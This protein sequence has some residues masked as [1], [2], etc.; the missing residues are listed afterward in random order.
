MQKQGPS[1]ACFLGWRGDGILKKL[2]LFRWPESTGVPSGGSLWG[3][4]T[5]DH[6]DTN[7]SQMQS[8]TSSRGPSASVTGSLLERV[9]S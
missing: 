4:G 2:R 6:W 3:E 8:S 9:F 7:G 5:D 1:P